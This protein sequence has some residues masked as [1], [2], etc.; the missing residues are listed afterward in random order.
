MIENAQRQFAKLQSFD[1][2]TIAANL[3]P[4]LVPLAP[5][6]VA[7]IG[8]AKGLAELSGFGYIPAIVSGAGME[9][10]GML[11]AHL[12]TNAIISRQLGRGFV[13]AVLLL[14]YALFAVWAISHTQN[15]EMFSA[16]V[17]LS[18]VGY[19]AGALWR[20]N[21]NEQAAREKAIRQAAVDRAAAHDEA[22]HSGA[23]ALAETQRQI[24]LIEAQAGAAKLLADAETRRQNSVNRGAK[25][26][27]PVRTNDTNTRTATRTV[28]P[29]A[30]PAAKQAEIRDYQKAHPDAT[31]REVSAACRVSVGSVDKYGIHGQ[32]A[33]T[34]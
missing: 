6:T 11:A 10:V 5:A 13:S 15:A 16:F 32:E 12:L 26:A 1:Y 2:I 29:R 31:V 25:I 18:V 24:M 8:M 27:A 9:M 3:A 14:T 33:A 30:L 20:Y 4:V 34:K 17:G 22:D 28:N 23:L 21:A 7:V 19:L